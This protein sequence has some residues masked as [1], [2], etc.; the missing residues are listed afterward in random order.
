MWELL[1]AKALPLPLPWLDAATVSERRNP[2]DRQGPPAAKP[3]WPPARRSVARAPAVA[4]RAQEMPSRLQKG[5][6]C[7]RAT[8]PRDA[9]ACHARQGL[10]TSTTN[11]WEDLDVSLT[12]LFVYTRRSVPW[13]PGAWLGASAPQVPSGPL[14]RLMPQFPHLRTEHA[15]G[16]WAVGVMSTEA[17]DIAPGAKERLRALIMM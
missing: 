3:T 17:L 1:G 12:L 8:R 11:L 6:R 5:P 10:A 2:G 13:W 16:T 15:E 4:S 9:P 14:C 7:H